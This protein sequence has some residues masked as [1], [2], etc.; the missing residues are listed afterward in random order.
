[1]ISEKIGVTNKRQSENFGRFRKEVIGSRL[2][3]VIMYDRR[4]RVRTIKR[5]S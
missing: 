4:K 2:K 3:E 1:M 5:G